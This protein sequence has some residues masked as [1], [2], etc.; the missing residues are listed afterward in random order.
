MQKFDY[1]I[2]II[3][4]IYNAEEYIE[5]SLNSILNQDDKDVTYEVLM[6]NDGSK[7]KSEEIC[8]KYS[9]NY[10]NF[11]YIYKENSGVS[12]TRNIGLDIAKGKYILFL[13]SDDM[14]T[15]ETLGHIFHLF[16][17][18]QNES[19]ILTYPLNKYI[20]GEEI[21]HLRS[22]NYYTEGLFKVDN[23]SNLNQVT[24]NTVVKNLPK[25]E[26]CYFNT[27]LKQS[28]DA[29]FNTQMIMKNKKIIISSKGAYLYRT[30]HKSTVNNFANPAAIKGMLLDFFNELIKLQ[31]D[32]G[33]HTY[34]Q[35]NILYEIN[36]RFKGN[37]LY[38]NYLGTEEREKWDQAFQKIMNYISIDTI[39]NQDHMDIYHKYYFIDKYKGNIK[40]DYDSAG[41]NYYS[42]KEKFLTV[43][44]FTMVFSKMTKSDDR[45]NVYGFLKSPLL[46]YLIQDLKFVVRTIEGDQK[47]ELKPNSTENYYKSKIPVAEFYDFEIE[48]LLEDGMEYEFWIIYKG[49]EYKITPYFRNNVYFQKELGLNSVILNNKVLSYQSKT[50]K[51][52]FKISVSTDKDKITETKKELSNKLMSRKHL[53]LFVFNKYY[54]M[55]KKYYN[56]QNIWLYTDRIGVFDNSFIQFQHDLNIRDGVKRYYIISEENI[57]DERLKNIPKKN[58]VIRNSNK[59]KI[60]F[61]F[62]KLVLT[63]FKDYEEYCPLSNQFYNT[64]YSVMKFKL[65]YLQH[66]ILHAHTPWLYSRHYT[67]VDKFVVSSALET[68]NLVT[69]YGY[70]ENQLIKTG[71]PRLIKKDPAN[72]KRKNKILFAPSW[73]ISI[74]RGQKDGAW[75]TDKDEFRNSVFYKGLIEFLKNE[76]LNKLLE[77]FDFDID[78]KLHPIFREM[79]PLFSVQNDR[80]NVVDN[81]L[82]LSEYKI[83]IT[84]FSSF[85]FDFIENNT[86]ILMYYPDYDYFVSG[87][88]I[89]NQLDFDLTPISKDYK[90]ASE[91]IKKLEETFESNCELSADES[92][93]Y[94]NFFYEV[95]NRKESLYKELKK[96]SEEE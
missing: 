36:W 91:L 85:L 45:I 47:I 24:I 79:S 18:F 86:K 58:L 50:E 55:S 71:M 11:K 1:D 57:N 8:L 7:D 40:L 77:K 41:I 29:L 62:S 30:E 81:D 69:N 64:F 33:L 21:E 14:L 25:D 9:E 94:N 19:D 28:E 5:E 89:Y 42:N 17:K 23:F 46:Q 65:I 54:Q 87:N 35:S 78:I 52:L 43:K 96:I 37:V 92:S 63:S 6:I 22:K 61:V 60:L 12:A 34:I 74:T 90:E 49:L 4:P 53:R 27:K 70:R 75:I 66:G 83:L 48:L 88:H 38:P 16:E 80:I 51:D 84:D 95:E 15:S 68:D 13:D 76:E 32:G 73:R 3:M 56:G 10:D 20:D 82:E 2:S 72:I 59:H 39:M 31:E 26:R 93:F 67:N 44:Q